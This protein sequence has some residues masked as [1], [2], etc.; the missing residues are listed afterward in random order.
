ENADLPIIIALTADAIES[1]KEKYVSKG[2]NDCLIKP[3]DLAGLKS[4]LDFWSEQVEE[5][6]WR[7]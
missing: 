3:L 4:T 7:L 5:S 6:H 2:M 1:S